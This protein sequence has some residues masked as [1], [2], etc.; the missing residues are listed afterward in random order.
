MECRRCSECE[1]MSHHWIADPI[2]PDHPEY[3]PGDH[4]CKH[5]DQRGDGCD[6][7]AGDGRLLDDELSFDDAPICP[8]CNGEGVLPVSGDT[9]EVE[10]EPTLHLGD[11]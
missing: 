4:A 9:G 6:L 5:C 11:A 2:D 3:V 1:G 10:D 7:C 8:N